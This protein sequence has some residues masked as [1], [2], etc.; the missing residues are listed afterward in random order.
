MLTDH[1]I[2]FGDAKI[3]DH[4]KLSI[5]NYLLYG[6][7]PGGFLTNILTGNLFNVF[8]S[9][10]YQNKQHIEDIV[11]WFKFSAPVNSY[12]SYEAIKYW[13][14]DPDGL[15]AKYAEHVEKQYVWRSLKRV[16]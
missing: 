3:P 1:L 13:V 11:N 9:A 14:T 7:P 15:R 10:D 8:S 6:L 4:T 5:Q 16:G 2:D 12:G